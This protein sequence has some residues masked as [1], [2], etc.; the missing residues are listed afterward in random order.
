MRTIFFLPLSLLLVGL[1]W[2]ATPAAAQVIDTSLNFG[3]PLDVPLYLSGTFAEPRANHFHGGLDIRTESREGLKVYAVQEGFVS[4]I[5]I[6]AFGYGNAIYIEHPSGYT[7]VYAHLSGFNAEIEQYIHQLHYEKESCN[8]DEAVPAGKLKVKKGEMVAYSGNTGGSGGPHLHFELRNTITENAINPLLYG[9]LVNDKMA[10]IIHN[11]YIYPKDDNLTGPV[12]YAARKTTTGYRLMKDTLYFNT[13]T[14]T[15]GLHA[16][17]KMENSGSTNGIYSLEVLVDDSAIYRFHMDSVSFAE[18]RYVQCHVDHAEKINDNNTVYRC[19]RLPGNNL[20]FVYDLQKNDGYLAIND[21]TLHK[22]V[23][24]SKDFQGNASNLTFYVG[25]SITSN[26]FKLQVLNFDTVFYHNRSNTFYGAGLKAQFSENTFY[27]K[28]FFNYDVDSIQLKNLQAMGPLHRLHKDSEPAHNSYS[29][30]LFVNEVP[31]HLHPKGVMVRIDRNGRI[32]AYS[33][34]HEGSWFT[35]NP[36]EFGNFTLLLDTLPPVIRPYN[37]VADAVITGKKDIRFT[38][39]DNLSNI[40]TY[41]ATINGKWVLLT[42]DYKNN[43]LFYTLDEHCLVGE[44]NF[45]LI[46]TDKAGN[47]ATY[48]CTFK[49]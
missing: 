23:L 48:M 41:R 24:E 7:S 47:S 1:V 43:L 22:V 12:S 30:S 6:A 4:R 35:A 13:D 5:K 40:D 10:P 29:L 31:Q 3:P 14:I 36:K 28:V 19:H 44:L 20:N 45:E 21:S 39:S 9:F 27:N 33:T 8:L 32:K 18:T 49:N 25:K 16:T 37:F 11:V 34:T 46:V 38:I 2:F 42:Y 15:F 26:A 17:D